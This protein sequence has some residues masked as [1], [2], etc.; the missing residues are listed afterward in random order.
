MNH[1]GLSHLT[2]GV[3]DPER[4]LAELEARGIAVRGHAR[5]NFVE[6]SP[7]FQF[8]FEDPDGLLIETYTVPPDES[9]PY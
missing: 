3:K 9:L 5:G 1:V 6:D 8:L 2:V 4:T 7:G